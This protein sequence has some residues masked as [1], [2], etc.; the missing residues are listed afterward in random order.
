MTNVSLEALY[1]L[2]YF[3]LYLKH[4]LGCFDL[5]LSYRYKRKASSND[6][7]PAFVELVTHVFN[8]INICVFQF[9][10][11]A[12]NYRETNQRKQHISGDMIK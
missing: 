10:I 1:Y 3:N 5:L 4:Y 6:T 12:V 11:H 8:D 2:H 7:V 9:R